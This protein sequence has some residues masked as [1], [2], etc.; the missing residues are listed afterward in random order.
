MI[1]MKKEGDTRCGKW[2]VL[3]VGPSVQNNLRD[4]IE[5]V[6]DKKKIPFQRLASSRR[7]S[8]DTDAFAY[9][10][11]G[12]ASALISLPLRYMHTTVEMVEAVDVEQTIQLMYETICALKKGQTFTY[13]Q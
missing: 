4:F 11:S 6:A 5:D 3:S 12:V 13:I 10:Q 9:A 1:N 7:T 8:T 2:P